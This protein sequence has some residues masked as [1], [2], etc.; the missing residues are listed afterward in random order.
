MKPEQKEIDLLK[1]EIIFLKKKVEQYKK[2]G[3]IDFLTGL[4]NRRAHDLKLIEIEKKIQ[5]IRKKEGNT[6]NSF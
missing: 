3:R 2:E 4:E 5:R 1:Q 6:K